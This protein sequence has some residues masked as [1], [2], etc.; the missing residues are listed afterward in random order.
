VQDR[1]YSKQMHPSM[2]TDF[3]LQVQTMSC[4]KSEDI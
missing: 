1:L 2:H 3:P 4:K